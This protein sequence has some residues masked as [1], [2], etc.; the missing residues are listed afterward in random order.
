MIYIS[1]IQ[2]FLQTICP[3]LRKEDIFESISIYNIEG[4]TSQKSSIYDVSEVS[5]LRILMDIAKSD[6]SSN[7]KKIAYYNYLM[8]EH[9]VKLIYEMLVHVL[10][11]GKDAIILHIGSHR[12]RDGI[13]RIEV[14]TTFIHDFFRI[15]VID[16]D[17]DIDIYVNL[18]KY[19]SYKSR[20]EQQSN[21]VYNMLEYVALKLN[22]SRIFARLDNG[23]RSEI[24]PMIDGSDKSCNKESIKEFLLQYGIPKDKL[25]SNKINRERFNKILEETLDS[26]SNFTR[27][28]L[29]R[30]TLLSHLI[31]M[32]WETIKEESK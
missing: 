7:D 18:D 31:P 3:I 30:P 23:F 16:M 11:N 22:V 1:S 32:Y 27:I 17:K 13:D 15:D 20:Y 21:I 12:F 24:D 26:K 5:Q 8:E 4:G 9:S 14:L 19:N 10:T 2:C 28:R 25:K 6:I 29:S